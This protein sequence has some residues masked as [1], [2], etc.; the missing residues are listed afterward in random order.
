MIQNNAR[1][2]A[3]AV[4]LTNPFEPHEKIDNSFSCFV[5]AGCGTVQNGTRAFEGHA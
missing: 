3:G 1:I 2:F 5:P 4:K